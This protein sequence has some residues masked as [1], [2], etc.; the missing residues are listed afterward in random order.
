MPT[1]TTVQLWSEVPLPTFP[2]AV[3]KL[4]VPYSLHKTAGRIMAGQTLQ[5]RDC[6]WLAQS[7]LDDRLDLL[8]IWLS[9]LE[10]EVVPFPVQ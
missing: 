7:F 2:F 5:P 4:I 6:A 9:R 10:Y 3:A 1:R 8:F